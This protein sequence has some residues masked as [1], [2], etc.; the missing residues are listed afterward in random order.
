MFVFSSVDLAGNFLLKNDSNSSKAPLLNFLDEILGE[1]EEALG[2]FVKTWDES[3]A[4]AAAKAEAKEG[5]V[6]LEDW[7]GTIIDAGGDIALLT[8]SWLSLDD[9]AG[10]GK[11]ILFILNGTGGD[12]IPDGG[13]E[14]TGGTVLAIEGTSIDFFRDTKSIKQST[15]WRK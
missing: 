4:E 10:T 13:F 9:E 12:L 14:A 1:I 6:I 5:P 3:W 8:I 11:G 15:K 2:L 7:E